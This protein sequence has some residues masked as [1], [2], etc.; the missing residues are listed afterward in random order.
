MHNFLSETGIIGFLLVFF[1]FLKFLFNILR[2]IFF[3]DLSQNHLIQIMINSS[4]IINLMPLIPSG[5]F[6]NNWL[7]LVLFLSLGFCFY[8]NN[9]LNDK[10][11]F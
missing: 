3:Y 7:S 11:T 2:R 5:N 10:S 4:I 6:F 1:V 8:V 9:K